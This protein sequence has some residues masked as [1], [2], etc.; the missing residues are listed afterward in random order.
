MAAIGSAASHVS[1]IIAPQDHV[2]GRHDSSQVTM[3]PLDQHTATGVTPEPTTRGDQ[4]AAWGWAPSGR[5]GA[6]GQANHDGHGVRVLCWSLC[7]QAGLLAADEA[8]I[9]ALLLLSGFLIVPVCALCL[10]GLLLCTPG[11]L[12][13]LH[14]SLEI[15]LHL[16][17]Q[18]EMMPVF[19]L[20]PVR[21]ESTASSS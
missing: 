1:S 12:R 20:L 13:L 21:M 15:Q 8:L 9:V 11:L 5:P 16:Q 7:R 18:L 6:I 17:L 4:T 10:L 14:V 3:Q 2:A 19:Y